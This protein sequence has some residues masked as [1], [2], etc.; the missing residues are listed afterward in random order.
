MLTAAILRCPEHIIGNACTALYIIPKRCGAL[1]RGR[2]RVFEHSS[3]THQIHT[4]QTPNK[5]YPPPSHAGTAP[6]STTPT[7]APHKPTPTPH[8]DNPH[9]SHP[10]AGCSHTPALSDNAPPTPNPT[11]LNAP[12][13]VSATLPPPAEANSALHAPR[14]THLPAPE[15]GRGR[16][17]F[18]LFWFWVGVGV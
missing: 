12:T 15:E 7:N 9:H 13:H 17:V 10:H 11:P 14:A 5:K 18:V 16:G 8:A 4:T 6:Y 2:G 3:S 1:S